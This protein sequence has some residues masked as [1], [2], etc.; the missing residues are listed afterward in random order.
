M[1]KYALAPETDGH[2]GQAAAASED[3]QTEAGLVPSA[4]GKEDLDAQIAR[5][6][7]AHSGAS[8]APADAEAARKPSALR[9]GTPLA[10]AAYVRLCAAG[11]C[12]IPWASVRICWLRAMTRVGWCD[13]SSSEYDID[14]FAAAVQSSSGADCTSQAILASAHEATER[15]SAAC[16]EHADID[17][18]ERYGC[19]VRSTSDLCHCE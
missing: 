9:F 19:A 3:A 4:A 1:C 16:D 6:S 14:A 13:S 8:A 11:G 12:T 5:H 2:E 18:N 10:A 17:S 7:H 15:V